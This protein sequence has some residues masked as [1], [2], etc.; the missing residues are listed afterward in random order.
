MKS[1]ARFA[2]GDTMSIQNTS[3]SILILIARR[4]GS[5]RTG[6]IRT[7]TRHS[8]SARRSSE[9]STDG[10][11]QTTTCCVVG[12]ISSSASSSKSGVQDPYRYDVYGSDI[13][14]ALDV[15]GKIGTAIRVGLERADVIIL[16][17]GLT[18]CW[19]NRANGMYVCRGPESENDE[20][21][22]QLEFRRS[23][24]VKNYENV[25][26]TI[27]RIL[28]LGTTKTIVLTVSL[29]PLQL[30]WTGQDIV[31]ANMASKLYPACRSRRCMPRQAPGSLLALLRVCV[32]A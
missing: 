32:A 16:T 29:V 5:C 30:T 6:T 17:L 23:G 15:S 14:A 1:E 19:R 27:D 13:D 24:F 3:T 22:S 11:G 21:F 12:R 31:V 4:W 18:E 9:S 8:R 25:A 2:H 10:L 20:L 7:I 26:A 28:T